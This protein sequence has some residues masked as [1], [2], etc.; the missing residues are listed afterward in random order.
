MAALAGE[1]T[2]QN[3][4]LISAYLYQLL[5]NSKSVREQKL[6]DGFLS[7]PIVISQPLSSRETTPTVPSLLSLIV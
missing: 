1:T 6:F 2:G 5:G 3:W 7:V 4:D